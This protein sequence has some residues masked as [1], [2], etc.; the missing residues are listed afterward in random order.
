MTLDVPYVRAHFPGLSDEW[1]LL[2]N[3]GGSPPLFGVIASW[4]G[5]LGPAFALLALPL[6]WSIWL[7]W[8]WRSAAPQAEAP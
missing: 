4:R 3:A 5:G 7:L 6:A 1:A 8:R 2:D